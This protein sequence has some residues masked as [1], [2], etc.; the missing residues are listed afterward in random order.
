VYDRF[1]QL[2]LPRL[3]APLVVLA[4]ASCKKDPPPAPADE[5]AN[6]FQVD[7]GVWRSAQPTTQAQWQHLKDLGVRHV[8]KLNF[9]SEGS[10]EGARAVGIEVHDLSIQPADDGH[11][12]ENVKDT[13]K[14]PD[15]EKIAEAERILAAGGG[16]LVHCTHGHDRT[17]LVVGLHRVLHDGWTKEAAYR[18]MIERHFHPELHGLHEYWEKFDGTL[19]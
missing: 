2:R 12:V 3:A 13:L 9:D 6:L 16:V 7:A 14:R 15:A 18:E 4:L 19:R 11:I 5:V 17:G 8:V 1:V 10:D